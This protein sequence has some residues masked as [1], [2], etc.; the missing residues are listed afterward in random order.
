MAFTRSPFKL[1]ADHHKLLTRTSL[2]YIK[3][4]DSKKQI[5]ETIPAEVKRNEAFIYD[6]LIKIYFDKL[7]EPTD[8][9]FKDEQSSYKSILC[10]YNLFCLNNSSTAQTGKCFAN[11]KGD[12]NDDY[13]AHYVYGGELNDLKYPFVWFDSMEHRN[14]YTLD[15]IFYMINNVFMIILKEM[16]REYTKEY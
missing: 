14:I 11:K 10:C 3:L 1:P 9:I 8:N 16:I 4:H 7:V 12:I 6:Y 13:L 5:K 15:K 2:P